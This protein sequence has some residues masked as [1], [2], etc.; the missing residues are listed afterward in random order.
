MEAIRDGDLVAVIV[1]DGASPGGFRVAG[2]CEG[3]AVPTGVEQAARG[4][5]L[6]VPCVCGET[7]L[8]YSGFSHQMP[9]VHPWPALN[10]ACPS[11]GASVSFLRLSAADA[12]RALRGGLGVAPAES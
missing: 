3:R 8:V 11:C 2:Y 5:G 10:Y 7:G 1:R 6:M 9:D 4:Q 12:R